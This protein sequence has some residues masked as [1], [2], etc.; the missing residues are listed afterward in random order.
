MG[1]L[2]V[3]SLISEIAPGMKVYCRFEDGRVTERK[4]KSW[5]GVL[6]ATQILKFFEYRGLHLGA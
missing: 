5:W 4:R 2:S 1:V 6:E 3:L